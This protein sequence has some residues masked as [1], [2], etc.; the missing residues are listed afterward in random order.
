MVANCVP[1]ARN[2]AWMPVP[3][4]CGRQPNMRLE[5]IRMIPQDLHVH[6]RFSCDSRAPMLEMCRA[7]LKVGIGEI[8]FSEH[9]DLMPGDLCRGFFK[10]DAW[11]EA[12]E[13]CRSAFAGSLVIRAGIEVGEAHRFSTEV[14]DVLGG[15]PWDYALGSLHWV[16]EECVLEESYFSRPVDQA[17][18]DYFRELAA[19]VNGADFDV[20]AHLDIVKRYGFDRYGEFKPERYEGEIRAVLRA[21]V[22]RDVALE[23]NTSGLRRPV[24]ET[25][26]TCRVLSWYRQEGGRWV[27][28]GSDAHEPGHVGFGLEEALGVVGEA[29]FTNLASFEARRPR[30][31]AFSGRR[32][33]A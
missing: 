10:A 7:A 32:G 15:Y 14:D 31:M 5:R 3:R 30:P 21:C 23:V 19:M 27:T 17:Y 24:G 12:L 8:G 25:L 22:D 16:D 2:A 6:T 26:P 9:F 4:T 11:W 29:G 13:R 1:A 28:L 18:R 20:L 33:S